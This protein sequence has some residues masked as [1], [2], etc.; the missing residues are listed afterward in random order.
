MG[1]SYATALLDAQ[2]I[3]ATGLSGSAVYIHHCPAGQLLVNFDKALMQLIRETK[4][5]QRMGIAVPESA[6]QVLAQEEKFKIYFNQLTYAL[7]VHTTLWS[8]L[9]VCICVVCLHQCA[10][11]TDATADELMHLLMQFSSASFYC[12]WRY[13]GC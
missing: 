5:L 3:P 7:K 6:R 8:D 11:L 10:M 12:I 4:H 9:A 2:L 1:P 13:L